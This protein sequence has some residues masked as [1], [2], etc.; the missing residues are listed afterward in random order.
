[1]AGHRF[2]ETANGS[3]FLIDRGPGRQTGFRFVRKR[4]GRSLAACLLLA[5][6]AAVHP[7]GTLAQTRITVSSR[8]IDAF[9][10][11]DRARNRFGALEFVGGLVLTSGEKNFG[12]LSAIHVEPDG[13][14]FLAIGDRGQWLRGRIVYAD[15]KPAGI[16]DA[17]MA[18]M[19]GRDG[20]ALA[21]SKLT[22]SESLAV[23]GGHAYVGIERN[24]R[25][26]RFNIGGD[27]L[28]ARGETLPAPPDFK[29]F[30]SNKGLECLAVPPAGTPFAGRLIAVTERSL[31]AARNVRAF[32]FGKDGA[33]GQPLRFA[34]KRTD[35]FDI[36]DCTVLP[37]GDLLLLERFYSL[38][39]GVAMRIRRVPLRAIEAGAVVDGEVLIR[40]D[41]G[42][43]IDNMEGLAAHRDAASGGTESENGRHRC[44]ERTP[45]FKRLCPA[46]L[47]RGSGE[48]SSPR[49]ASS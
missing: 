20:K 32:V 24:H 27:G 4:S 10:P 49:P 3:G 46:A 37:R 36:T 14:R 26:V 39:R 33:L 48:V 38:L 21:A 13:A 35:D 15:G 7:A 18:P 28:R 31:D 41:L 40:A 45:F 19:L 16:A 44:S 42:Y 8:Q 1:M 6:F 12:G 43:E 11:R 25:I 17:E 2:A 29:T 9:N 23:S 22:D 47:Q 5:A 34:V 30:A